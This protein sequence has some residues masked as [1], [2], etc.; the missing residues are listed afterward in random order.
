MPKSKMRNGAGINIH[1]EVTANLLVLCVQC[2]SKLPH[3]VPSG[4]LMSTRGWQLEGR[5]SLRDL[6][7]CAAPEG[8]AGGM[9]L[10]M[11][12]FNYR[13]VFFPGGR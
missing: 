12:G 13:A 9:T 1:W 7:I 10:H 2:N 5:L 3:L 11:L 6:L 4:S 8:Q